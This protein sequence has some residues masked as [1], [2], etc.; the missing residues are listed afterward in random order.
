MWVR[1]ASLS[2]GESPGEH[3]LH[4]PALRSAHQGSE[5]CV[6]LLH[7]KGLDEI[8]VRSAVQARD[9]VGHG[10]SGR[11]HENGHRVGVVPAQGAAEG[12]PVHAGQ[13]DVQHDHVKMPVHGLPESGRAAGG[14]VQFVAHG[15]E[16]GIEVG[17]NVLIVFHKQ[18]P[19]AVLA[20]ASPHGAVRGG[21][22]QE[23]PC[24]RPCHM[25]G[26]RTGLARLQTSA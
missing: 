1:R 20:H 19:D 21:R 23:S 2:G 26:M 6:E 13:H 5:S 4:L 12:E 9:P 15:F 14:T 16:K 22:E 18:D 17:G 25:F 24:T 7:G 8:V 10:V 11:E 3:A